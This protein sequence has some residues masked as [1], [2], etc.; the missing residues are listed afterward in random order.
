[1]KFSTKISW[2]IA[3]AC[4]IYNPCDG[5]A[6]IGGE[7]ECFNNPT[8]VGENDTA[9]T[10]ET[11]ALP[12]ATPP[13]MPVAI[14]AI[15]HEDWAALEP[16]GAPQMDK[17]LALLRGEDA[18]VEF[19]H[20][21]DTFGSHLLGTF[22]ILSAWGQSKD[23]A[24]VGLFHTA[25][26]GDAF[27]FHFFESHS[28]EDR[29]ALRAVVGTEAERLVH[30]FGTMD[31][32]VVN[33]SLFETPTSSLHPSPRAIRARGSPEGTL[34]VPPK[35]QAAIMV[36]TIADYL[37]QMVSVNGWRDVHQK[38]SPGSLYPGTGK[39]EV[40]LFWFSRVCRGIRPFLQV[41]PPIFNNCTEE[42][43]RADEVAA[44]D[45]YW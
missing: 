14:K 2:A 44:R 42:L 20:A 16:D 32:S 15:L 3:S 23:I 28:D 25:F 11:S 30:L 7:K 36:T 17:A 13:Y 10:F 19:A 41:A 1:M 34:P 40:A 18:F 37:D 27:I 4:I 35:D 6:V 26:S 9:P 22:S 8:T 45:L 29:A 21:R 12:T 33:R 39:P 31:R 43:S 38:K 5:M 24:R